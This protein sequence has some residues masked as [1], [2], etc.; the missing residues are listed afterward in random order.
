MSCEGAYTRRFRTVRIENF[1]ASAC[2]LSGLAGH[3]R[4]NK[5]EQL[6]RLDA[7]GSIPMTH[8]SASNVKSE[9]SPLRAPQTG[10]ERTAV[11]SSVEGQRETQN[12]RSPEREARGWEDRSSEA[13]PRWAAALLLLL[14]V[15]APTGI[16]GCG[17]DSTCPVGY[18]CIATSLDPAAHADCI[19]P[20]A[21]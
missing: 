5:S 20:P 11:A 21:S 1:F 18:V 6:T 9:T 3:S 7:T 2:G 14:Q 17:D 13:R 8:K 10:S 19:K 12:V 15:A 16:A 4:A